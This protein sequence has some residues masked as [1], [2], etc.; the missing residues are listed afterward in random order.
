MLNG[1]NAAG[2]EA[3][4]IADAL[5]VVDD[6]PRGVAGEQEVPVQGVYRP[7]RVD[8]ARRRHQRLA[9]HLSAEDALPALV[10]AGA[11][12]QIVLQRLQVEGGEESVQRGLRRVI[13]GG[14]WGLAMVDGEG[15]LA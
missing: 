3:T 8:R 5:D 10:A 13:G 12:E 6:G 14:H 15:R 2:G 7:A 1:L 9:K 11:T 4:A